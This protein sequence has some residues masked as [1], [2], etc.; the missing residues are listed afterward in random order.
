MKKLDNKLLNQLIKNIIDKLEK[1][2]YLYLVN[3]IY[4][5]N[6]LSNDKILW[7]FENNI[8][9]SYKNKEIIIDKIRVEIILLIY[10]LIN[11]LKFNWSI[12]FEIIKCESPDFI[13]INHDKKIFMV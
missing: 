11:F 1:V 12:N 6:L 9:S 13:V 7:L 10:F 4:E 3:F 8:N 5:N 2:N